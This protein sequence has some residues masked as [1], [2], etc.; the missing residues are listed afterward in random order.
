MTNLYSQT[1]VFHIY[2]I[3]GITSKASNHGGRS[4]TVMEIFK[5][6]YN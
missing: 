4:W 1:E 6:A 5:V 3:K 2:P